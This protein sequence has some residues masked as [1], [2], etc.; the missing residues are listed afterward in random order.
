MVKGSINSL[1][2]NDFVRWK[3]ARLTSALVQPSTEPIPKIASKSDEVTSLQVDFPTVL[4][5]HMVQNGRDPVSKLT[6]KVVHIVE[7]R[8]AARGTRHAA[9]GRRACM[10]S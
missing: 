4:S 3:Q 9:S 2:V 10:Y 6:A 5:R 1:N 7:A 8:E